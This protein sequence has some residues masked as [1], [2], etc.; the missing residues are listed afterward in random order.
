M[1]RRSDARI[2]VTEGLAAQVSYVGDLHLSQ[3][4]PALFEEICAGGEQ[5]SPLSG[6]CVS[7]EGAEYRAS[8]NNDIIQLTRTDLVHLGD[9]IAGGWI[10]YRQQAVAGGAHHSVSGDVSQPGASLDSHG[11]PFL[12]RSAM[13]THRCLM[14]K[15]NVA[16][17]GDVSVG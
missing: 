15:G 14:D 12:V 4:G 3:L 8:P 13:W 16:S 2:Q 7:P 1:R 17:A 11:A 9:N 6:R 10:Q 5:S